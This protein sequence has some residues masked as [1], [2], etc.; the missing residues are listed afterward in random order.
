[1]ANT[2]FMLIRNVPESRAM[3]DAWYNSI[4]NSKTPITNDQPPFQDIVKQSR[5][6]KSHRCADEDEGFASWFHKKKISGS[7]L[8]KQYYFSKKHLIK[9]FHA[10][11]IEKTS[12][13][14]EVLKRLGM[15]YV[16]QAPKLQNKKFFIYNW[17]IKLIN[18]RDDGNLWKHENFGAGPLIDEVSGQFNTYMH[19]LFPIVLQRLMLHPSRTFHEHEAS[20]F[21]IPYDLTADAYYHKSENLYEVISLLNKSAPFLAE[22]G[23]NH[24]FVDSSEPFWYI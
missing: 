2:G 21:F 11:D 14:V 12:K 23:K 7:G 13:K 10:N 22:H 6:W 16:D 19:S 5:F 17:P 24:F 1:M 18:L 15:W 4:R 8:N 9:V 3:I 20:L